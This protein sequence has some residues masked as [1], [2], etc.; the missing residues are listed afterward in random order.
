MRVVK[1][2]HR[3]LTEAVESLSLEI[4][5]IHLGNLLPLSPL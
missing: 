3:L 5:K 2:W 4:L 1:H